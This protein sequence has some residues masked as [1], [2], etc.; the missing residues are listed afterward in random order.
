MYVMYVRGFGLDVL[1]YNHEGACP[2]D[3]MKVHPD[4]EYNSTRSECTYEDKLCKTIKFKKV[5]FSFPRA[6]ARGNE[7]LTFL[8]FIVVQNLT[9]YIHDEENYTTRRSPKPRMY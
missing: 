7:K 3:C 5:N 1:L 6:Q 8:N 4:K 2:S 9:T